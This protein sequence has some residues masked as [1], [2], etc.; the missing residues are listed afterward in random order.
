MKTKLIVRSG[1][2]VLRFDE[3]NCSLT[4]FSVL[5]RVGNTNTKMNTLVKKL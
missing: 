3:K 4:P 1:I 2:I 5:L